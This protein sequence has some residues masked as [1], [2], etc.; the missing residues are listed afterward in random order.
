M[1]FEDL[2][3]AGD[4][5]SCGLSS[6]VSQHPFE[7]LLKSL[8]FDHN[9]QKMES[10]TPISKLTRVCSVRCVDENTVCF[11]GLV[12][13]R[14]TS[15]SVYASLPG[16]ADRRVTLRSMRT[17]VLIPGTRWLMRGRTHRTRHDKCCN[18]ISASAPIATYSQVHS[19][20]DSSPSSV[21]HHLEPAGDLPATSN[22]QQ[23]SIPE[24]WSRIALEEYP[25]RS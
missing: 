2:S 17:I 7:L 3:P 6:A 22:D 25:H 8:Y 4:R 12:T 11:K 16:S 15:I 1:A 19:A 20:V 14:Q 10:T 24:Y 21:A 13:C 18:C 5:D 23:R 9:W